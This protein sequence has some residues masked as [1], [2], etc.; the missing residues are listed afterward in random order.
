MHLGSRRYSLL[1]GVGLLSALVLGPGVARA[2]NE[3]V[4]VTI[5]DKGCDP[6]AMTVQPGKTVFK[7]KNASKRAI[8]FEILQGNMVVEERENIIPGFVQNVT[9]TLDAGDYGMT[10]GLLSNPKGS[11][12]VEASVEPKK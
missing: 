11:L 7:I 1:A 3:P 5:T 10:C 2:D 8:E 9:A 12:K 6:L 4:S